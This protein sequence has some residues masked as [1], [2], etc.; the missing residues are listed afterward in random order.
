MKKKN[1]ILLVVLIIALVS[2]LLFS[3]FK[4]H[5]K[6]I[7][8]VPAVPSPSPKTEPQVINPAG[9]TTN[10]QEEINRLKNLSAQVPENNPLAIRL[11]FAMGETYVKYGQIDL[12]IECFKKVIAKY[13]GDK[14]SYY[15]LGELY[16][17]KGDIPKGIKMWKIF[18]QKDPASYKRNEIEK[19]LQEHQAD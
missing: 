11:E 2:L 16:I 13:P 15:Y 4:I 17:T 6:T 7:E 18:L 5:T 10:F 8:K 14:K 1:I 3:Y 9:V 19:F 12:A